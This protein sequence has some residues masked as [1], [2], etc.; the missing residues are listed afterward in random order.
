MLAEAE[1]GRKSAKA[2]VVGA[3]KQARSNAVFFEK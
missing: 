3:E 2:A 1:W